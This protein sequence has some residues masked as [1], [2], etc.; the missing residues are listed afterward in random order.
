MD[1]FSFS[2]NLTAYSPSTIS[3]AANT[4][5][6]GSNGNSV[7]F[8]NPITLNGF[9]QN[10]DALTFKNLTLNGGTSNV[11]ITAIGANIV[12]SNY[13]PNNSI[14][15]TV[16]RSGNQTFYVTSNPLQYSLT[17]VQPPLEKAG[18]TQMEKSPSQAQPLR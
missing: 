6:L 14:S 3:I 2:T 9:R 8:V 10:G 15:Y 11:T 5:F 13:N 1:Q 17:A 18:D 12:L 16:S 4:N 7:S